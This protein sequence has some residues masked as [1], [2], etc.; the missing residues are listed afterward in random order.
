M[1]SQ[2]LQPHLLA[3]FTGVWAT[4]YLVSPR[5][6]LAAHVNQLKPAKQS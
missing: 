1:T 2:F 4:F 3:G 5:D 6:Q